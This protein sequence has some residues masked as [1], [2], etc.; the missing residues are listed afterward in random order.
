VAGFMDVSSALCTEVQRLAVGGV[1]THRWRPIGRNPPWIG[2]VAQRTLGLP[3]AVVSCLYPLPHGAD[4]EGAGGTTG[5][6]GQPRHPAEGATEARATRAA[7]VTGR[8]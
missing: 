5:Y 4:C 8:V 3:S 7:Q 6:S 2:H 1:S